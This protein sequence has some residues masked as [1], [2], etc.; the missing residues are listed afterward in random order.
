MERSPRSRKITEVTTYGA[1]FQQRRPSTTGGMLVGHAALKK[2]LYKP[3]KVE[4]QI[5]HLCQEDLAT[6]EHILLEYVTVSHT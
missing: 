4:D 3:G 5:C 6:A 2:Y 1:I